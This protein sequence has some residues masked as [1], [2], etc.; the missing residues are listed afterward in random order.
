MLGRITGLILVS[1]AVAG[2][3]R[4]AG[5]TRCREGVWSEKTQSARPDRTMVEG[6]SRS[7]NYCLLD[8]EI[9]MA[10]WR[11]I[12][13]DDGVT[14]RGVGFRSFDEP[15][16][17]GKTLWIMVGDPGFTVVHHDIEGSVRRSKGEGAD[18]YGTFL[19]RSTN[20]ENEDGS[21]RFV[22][23][24][25]Y[26]AGGFWISPFNIIDGKLETETPPALPEQLVPA[27]AGAARSATRKN[28]RHA[29][30][31]RVLAIL[32]GYA[33]VGLVLRNKKGETVRTL[34]FSSRY[35]DPPR[36]RSVFWVP[37]AED[38]TVEETAL[39]P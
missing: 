16:T 38:V 9:T 29:A 22:M 30:G 37:G 8:G 12:G 3:A 19:E 4:G 35:D 24:R 11:A 18:D 39:R 14:F 28:Q 32:D 15:R 33:E 10:E 17:A 36:W 21:Y 13:P 25:S 2:A 27:L 7:T 6:R 34:R 20:T 26:D 1:L 5:T 31:D 23:D